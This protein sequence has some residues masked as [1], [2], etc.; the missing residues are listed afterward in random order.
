MISRRTEA[1]FLFAGDIILLYAA[2]FFMLFIRY[3]AGLT[4]RMVNLHLLS[5]SLLFLLWVIV[6]FVAGL[7]ERHTL[8]FQ[9]RLPMLLTTTLVVDGLLAVLLFYFVPGLLIT[10]RINLFIYLFVSFALIFLWRFYGAAGI[11]GGVRERGALL[12]SGSEF[13]ELAAEVNA[14]PRYNLE[15]VFSADAAKE[16]SAEIEQRLTALVREGGVALVAADLRSPLFQDTLP[17]FYSL[18]FSR[19]RFL[20]LH[21]LY[22]EIF[23]RVPLSLLEHRWFLEQASV[24]GGEVYTLIKRLMDIVLALPL[25][26]LSLLLLP[27]VALAIQSEGRGPVFIRQIRVGQDGRPIEILKFRTMRFNDNGRWDIITD[28][29]N[30]VT[31][32]GRVLRTLRLDEFPALWNVLKGDLSLIGP[33]PEFPEAVAHYEAVVPF[34][35][36]RHLLKPGLSGWAQLYGEHPHHETDVAKTRNK[37]SYDLYYLKNRSFLLDLTIALKTLKVLLSRSGV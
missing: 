34:Y 20:S 3:G 2:L 8:L 37:L 32:V 12:G 4:A 33:R 36:M 5:F 28:E 30:S 31:R 24:G 29:Q 18:L 35:R 16:N 10:P 1:V 26:L 14:N 9:R 19:V 22:E 13:A 23:G 21:T 17:F 25:L 27:F 6:F 15:F 11:G 7:Y